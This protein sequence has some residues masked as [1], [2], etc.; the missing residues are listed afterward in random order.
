MQADCST[1]PM[2]MYKVVDTGLEP[3]DC[4]SDV[5][6]RYFRGMPDGSSYTLC[7]DYNWRSGICISVG[8]NSGQSYVCGS[9]PRS[10][11]GVAYTLDS[12]HADETDRGVCAGKPRYVHEKRRYVVCVTNIED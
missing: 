12:I 7:L 10:A 5:D 9:R 3:A 4:P 6:N 8:L 11:G 1:T 2:S